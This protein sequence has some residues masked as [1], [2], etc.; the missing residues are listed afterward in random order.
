[1]SVNFRR[2]LRGCP[3]ETI[4]WLVSSQQQSRIATI[5][6]VS[7]ASAPK[8]RSISCFDK[9]AA[10]RSQTPSKDFEM[11]T[12]PFGQ[13]TLDRGW[14]DRTRD[15]RH[16]PDADG[17]LRCAAQRLGGDRHSRAIEAQAERILA[18]IVTKPDSTLEELKAVLAAD[19][20]AFSVSRCRASSSAGTSRSKK[21]RARRRAGAAGRPEE[22]GG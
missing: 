22:A 9:L 21:D 16:R 15:A 4:T 3:D 20:H 8:A 11:K 5:S 2:R 6:S 13:G 1:V 10:N 12:G 17:A 18:L 7:G 19:G 14:Q